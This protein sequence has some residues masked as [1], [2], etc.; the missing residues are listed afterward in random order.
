MVK[1]VMSVSILIAVVNLQILISSLL[2]SAS[3]LNIIN[4][5]YENTSAVCCSVEAHVW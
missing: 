1:D 3:Q 4:Q 2:Q 5:N